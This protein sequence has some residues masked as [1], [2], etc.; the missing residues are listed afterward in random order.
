[1]KK[2]SGI[3]Y[4]RYRNL[5]QELAKYGYEY[6]PKKALF[7]YGMIVLV[8]AIFGL[9][10]KLELPYI[11]A[12]GIIGLVFSPMVI[13]QTMKGRYHTTM[14]SLANNYMEQFL[15]SFKRNG[16]VLNALLETATIFDE[17]IF[18]EALE[19]AIEHIQYTTDSEDP[20]REALDIVGE[21]FHC[22]RID[23]IHSFVIGAQRRGGDAGGS[24]FLLAKNRAM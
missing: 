23:A 19:R 6:T 10:Y 18:H 8:A 11:A 24:I 4:L 12:I 7:A 5:T 9:L 2:K 13:L 1:M 16:T 20:E 17:G 14:F 22:E 15:Y 3:K 21:F